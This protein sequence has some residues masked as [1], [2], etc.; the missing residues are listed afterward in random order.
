MRARTLLLAILAS[1]VGW[2]GGVEAGDPSG[3]QGWRGPE[4]RLDALN[5]S[6]EQ[7]SQVSAAQAEFQR[8]AS[9]IR[10]QVKAGGLTPEQG[11]E[12]IRALREALQ[13][14]IGSILTDEQKAQLA[15]QRPG[16][17]ALGMPGRGTPGMPGRG[18]QS[19][20]PPRGEKAG[21]GLQQALGLTDEQKTQLQ[22]LF[23]AQRDRKR[24]AMA[25]SGS[26][27]P[28]ERRALRQQQQETMR[29]DMAKILTPEQLAKLDAL[30]AARAERHQNLPS[31]EETAPSTS[32]LKNVAAPT[33]VM[34][35]SWGRIKASQVEEKAK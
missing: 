18:A 24:E 29:A 22:D 20:R 7:R 28:E 13:A 26:L 5:L 34:P 16:R 11:R 23:K 33:A 30:R 2:I 12:Q 35:Q 19:V 1:S 17:G 27:T 4:G 21:D 25:Q 31:G 6:E 14:T 3:R 10:E 9:P 15:Q 8:Q 32:A